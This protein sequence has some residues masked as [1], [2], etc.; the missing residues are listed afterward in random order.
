M[1]RKLEEDLEIEGS[2]L[3]DDPLY[4][5]DKNYYKDY[6]NCIIDL[7]GFSVSLLIAKELSNS[8]DDKGTSSMSKDDDEEW[9]QEPSGDK[10]PVRDLI[11]SKKSR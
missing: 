5:P 3:E 6:R 10:E 1:T 2:L 4:H 7:S 8:D 11:Q 9:I